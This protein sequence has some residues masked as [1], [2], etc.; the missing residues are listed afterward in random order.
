[1]FTDAQP[2]EIVRLPENPLR[3][4]THCLSFLCVLTK[5][6][7]VKYAVTPLNGN[8][9]WRSTKFLGGL[10]THDPHGYTHNDIH[11]LSDWD[12]EWQL[13]LNVDKCCRMTYT[14]SIS[15][16]CNTKYGFKKYR[17]DK[18]NMRYELANTDSVSGLG[19]RLDS[20]LSF[21]DHINDN[22]KNS[23]V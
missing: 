16:L 18:G 10:A 19:V 5:I 17:I 20:K 8:A 9:D 6:L 22:V 21:V 7:C 11:R 12:D 15:N 13:K 1:M 14:A 4:L 3:H 2:Y 23:K